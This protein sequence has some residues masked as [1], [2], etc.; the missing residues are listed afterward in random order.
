[1]T[2]CILILFTR[3][4]FTFYI[5]SRNLILPRSTYSVHSSQARE[6]LR[7]LQSLLLTINLKLPCNFSTAGR[8]R[9]KEY[10][11]LFGTFKRNYRSQSLY[12]VK[13]AIFCATAISVNV[14]KTREDKFHAPMSASSGEFH[15]SSSRYLPIGKSVRVCLLNKE[16]SFT[17]TR[18]CP[19][20]LAYHVASAHAS[21]ANCSMHVCAQLEI[22]QSDVCP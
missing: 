17:Y 14:R 13:F 7:V 2:H 16:L 10:K 22:P 8:R 3:I 12:F 21:C 15:G 11:E 5:T 6:L 4:F 19:E 9:F 1:M 18:V 20:W